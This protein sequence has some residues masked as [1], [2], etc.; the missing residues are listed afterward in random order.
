M[1]AKILTILSAFAVC[2]ILAPLQSTCQDLGGKAYASIGAEEIPAEA[3]RL[4]GAA[5]AQS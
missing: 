1:V 5:A 2:V 3:S 4:L